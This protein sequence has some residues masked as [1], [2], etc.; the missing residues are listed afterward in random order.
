MTRSRISI[1]LFLLLSGVVAAWAT[2]TTIG[3]TAGSGA[4]ANLISFASTHVM[5]E[6]GI[7]DATTENQCAA[8]NASGA[9]SVSATGISAGSAISG[10][11]GSGIM[12]D[13]V[14]APPSP[15]SNATLNWAT[16]DL[17]GRLIT[18]PYTNKENAAGG[19]ATFTSGASTVIAAN[20]S[21]KTY[22]TD[23]VC[24]NSS[25]TAVIVTLNDTLA[26]EIYVPATGGNNKS[27][28]VPIV[29]S[30]I[31]TAITGTPSGNQTTVKCTMT[32]F[33]GG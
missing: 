8:V 15:Y 18:K 23:W 31:N 21:Y 17:E 30:A 3:V 29:T 28:E 4:V 25:A 2:N 32:G 27:L 20:A 5:S 24:Y 33:Y 13:A 11:T 22:V 26:T 10:S 16:V 9:L 6:V 14:S 12:A 7:C 19:K 1:A